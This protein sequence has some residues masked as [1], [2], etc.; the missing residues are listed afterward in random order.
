MDVDDGISKDDME[1]ATGAALGA[2][3]AKANKI[4]LQEETKVKNLIAECI[5][6][7]LNKI[8]IKLN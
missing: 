8:E 1:K 4:L 6:N 3:A 7:A 5:E 2:A